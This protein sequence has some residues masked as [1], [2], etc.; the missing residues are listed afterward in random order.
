MVSCLLIALFAAVFF[1]RLEP[2]TADTKGTLTVGF[3]LTS[4]P[5]LQQLAQFFLPLA[6][7]S[8]LIM[9]AGQ[10]SRAWWPHTGD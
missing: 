3:C 5:T 9:R 6:L 10:A 2:P 1:T 8:Y 7:G 4:S